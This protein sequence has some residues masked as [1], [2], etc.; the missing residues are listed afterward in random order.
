MTVEEPRGLGQRKAD[1]LAKLGTPTLDGWVA[2]ASVSKRGSARAHVVPLS[3]VWLDG[4]VL[5][6]VEAD[7]VTARNVQ[8]HGTARIAIGPTRDVVVIDAVF[9]KAVAVSEAPEL[10]DAYAGQA[11]WDP[12]TASGEWVYMVLRPERIQAWRESNELAGRTLMRE[13]AWLA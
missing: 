10:A 3:L 5:I 8:E 9:E 1:A 4:R 11:D 13:G 12:R 2:S 7:S 6:S